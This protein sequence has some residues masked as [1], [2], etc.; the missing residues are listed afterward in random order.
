[1]TFLLTGSDSA[2]ILETKMYFK[3][4]FVTKDMERPKYFLGVEVAHQKHNVLLK[5]CPGSSGGT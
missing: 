1:M 2:G 4:H 3:H 5:I